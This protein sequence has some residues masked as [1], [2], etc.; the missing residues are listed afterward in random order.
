M[1]TADHA[2]R[3][4]LAVEVHRGAEV[5]EQDVG[6]R[7]DERR[8]EAQRR[9]ERVGEGVAAG[10]AANRVR[11]VGRLAAYVRNYSSLFHPITDG[12]FSAVSKR[13]NFTER[14]HICS[15]FR[16][17]HFFCAQRTKDLTNTAH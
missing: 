10:V 11:G 4:E 12:S 14:R 9:R 13:R 2:A 6:G 17:L 7:D 1:T 8:R 16:P 3:A 15:V 5:E